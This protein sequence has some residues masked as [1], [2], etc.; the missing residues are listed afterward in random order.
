MALIVLRTDCGLGQ[1]KG[2]PM[3]ELEHAFLSYVQEDSD[4]VDE[5]EA[6]LIAA[7]VAVWRDRNDL[8][9]GQDWK[10]TIRAAIQNGSLAFIACLSSQSLVKQKSFM[11]EELLLATDEFRL[12]PAGTQW[13]FPVRLDECDLPS[14]DLGGNRTLASL[15]YTDLFGSKKNAS[16]V[17]LAVAVRGLLTPDP[18]PIEVTDVVVSR[19][20]TNG[21]TLVESVKALLRDPSGDINLEELMDEVVEQAADELADQ[22]RF[23]SAYPLSNNVEATRLIRRMMADYEQV[24]E[25]LT[26]AFI[27]AGL[28]GQPQ[29]DA[30]WA[31]AME[32]IASEPPQTGNS[33]LISLHD[34]PSVWLLHAIGV[35]STDRQNFSPSRAAMIDAQIH[36]RGSEGP[37]LGFISTRSV[38]DQFGW[39]ASAIAMTKEASEIDEAFVS[40]LQTGR[41]GNR[42]TPVSDIIHDRMRPLF[43]RRIRSDLTYTRSFDRASALMDASTLD[44]RRRTR[45][46]GS[47]LPAWPGL[48]AYMWR[49]QHMQ[50]GLEETMAKELNSQSPILRAGYFGG[51]PDRAIAAFEELH[52]MVSRREGRWG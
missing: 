40:S 18:A 35:A 16:L 26:Q 47:Y 4:A 30:I 43:Q 48:S 14:L 50:E 28:F 52:D 2:R 45:Q 34:Y 13:F 42:F 11:N 39:M 22:E 7:G 6:A 1:T 10:Q 33:L 46:A 15:Q 8:A 19:S 12:R 25:P 17:R 51:E 36:R 5:I 29:H 38:F 44:L 32:G 24:L 49:Y 20:S 3:A 37:V 9:P 23:P 31:R 41:R 21:S 27:L